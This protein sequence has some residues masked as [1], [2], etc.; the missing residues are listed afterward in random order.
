MGNEVA[1]ATTF[2]RRFLAIALLPIPVLTGSG[3][4]SAT[5]VTGRFIIG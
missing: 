3:I 2:R 1:I 4:L 5:G